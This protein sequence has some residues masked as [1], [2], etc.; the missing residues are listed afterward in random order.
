MIAEKIIRK[1]LSTIAEQVMSATDYI[2][3]DFDRFGNSKVEY[4]GSRNLYGNNYADMQLEMIMTAQT[5]KKA[6]KPIEH[7]VLSY[8]KN[9]NPTPQDLQQA[10]DVF[11]KLSKLSSFIRRS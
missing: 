10:I 4:I 8:R 1:D 5:S 6:K 2:A 9:E 11:L 3:K 7:W